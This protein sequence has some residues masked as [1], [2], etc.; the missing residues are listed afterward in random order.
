MNT[1]P[2]TAALVVLALLL[3]ACEHRYVVEEETTCAMVSEYYGQAVDILF[4]IDS[5]GSMKDE[6]ANLVKNFPRLIEALRSPRLAVAFDG[7]V[8]TGAPRRAERTGVP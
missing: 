2:H 1:Q 6:Q 4:V 5:S 7:P 3:P 8:A